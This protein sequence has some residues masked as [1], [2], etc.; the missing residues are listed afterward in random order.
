[1]RS[2]TGLIWTAFLALLHVGV[3]CAGEGGLK[4]NGAL[5]VFGTQLVNEHGEAIQL[6][7][8]STHGLHWYP[9]YICSTSINE[10][11][12]RGANMF[13]LAMYA[14]SEHGGYSENAES[15][16]QNKRILY[17]GIENA[18][19]AD[20]YVIVD[21]HLLADENPLK[22]VHNAIPFFEEVAER[23]PDHPAII[24]E[25]CNEPNGDTT[26]AD[27]RA[28]AEQVIPAIRARSPN[29][30]ILV[31]TPNHSNDVLAVLPEPLDFPNILYSYHMYTGHSK[32][33]FRPKLD[34][35]AAAGLPVFVTEWGLS[36]NQE[37]GEL[38]V[39]EAVAFIKYMREHNISWA[40]WSLANKDEEH[41]AI[42]AE[43]KR[44]TE[45]TD[46]DLTVSGKLIFD[47][48]KGK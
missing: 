39:D 20:M 9:E 31:G 29:A 44:L 10:T 48:L 6:R 5:Q 16:E 24:Y 35:M 22:I 15:A 12:K 38:E 47:A 14:D 3:L 32:G 30:V 26:W 45:W 11:K 46:D 37:T 8:M 25:I 43:V 41:S 4:K 27:I 23:Y 2:G 33:D 18:L 17:Q 1:M 13:R 36:T 40:N 21:W 19:A 28:Y 34:A 7:G 42:R